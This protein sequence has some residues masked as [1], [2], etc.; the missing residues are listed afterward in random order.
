MAANQNPSGF[1]GGGGFLRIMGIIYLVKQIR[2][3]RGDRREARERAEA[4][5]SPS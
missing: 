3:R 2:K 4:E 5:R 1:A